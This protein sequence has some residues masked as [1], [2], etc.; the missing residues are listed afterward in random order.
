[1][2]TVLG[3]RS[4]VNARR[5]T[6]GMSHSVVAPRRRIA[7]RHGGMIAAAGTRHTGSVPPTPAAR[8]GMRGRGALLF[9]IRVR[10][11]A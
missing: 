8:S 4:I 2:T 3:A 11:R 7:V 5:P 6:T 10:D 1:M 9:V